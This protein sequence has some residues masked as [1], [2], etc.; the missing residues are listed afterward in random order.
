MNTTP[1]SEWLF[2]PGSAHSSISL[3]NMFLPNLTLAWSAR[4]S[5]VSVTWRL[6]DNL[7]TRLW[8]HG[9][10]HFSHFLE[11]CNVQTKNTW[12]CVTI[13]QRW[14]VET[15]QALNEQLDAAGIQQK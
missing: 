15:A 4:E 7:S 3:F 9:P 1:N 13:M 12:S 11:I 2:Y 5:K 8:C 6:G 10:F 14:T